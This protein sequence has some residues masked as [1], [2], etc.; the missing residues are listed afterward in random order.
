M[1]VA[2]VQFARSP[3]EMA[4]DDA[5]R[6]ANWLTELVGIEPGS[7]NCRTTTKQTFKD[8]SLVRVIALECLLTES[9]KTK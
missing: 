2:A 6:V 5:S 3:I 9:T 7:V 1:V 8:F 4:S